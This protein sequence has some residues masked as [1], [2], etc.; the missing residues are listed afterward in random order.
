M[1]VEANNPEAEIG[2]SPAA[3]S[4]IQGLTNDAAAKVQ[5]AAQ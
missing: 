2:L 3:N 5:Q 4:I 1:A